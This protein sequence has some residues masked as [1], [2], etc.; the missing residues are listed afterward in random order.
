[1]V[2]SEPFC[3]LIAVVFD[4]WRLLVLLKTMSSSVVDRKME[5]E[6]EAALNLK[7]SGSDGHEE[8][9]VAESA[10]E[11]EVKDD[12]EL[13][14]DENGREKSETDEE[15][16]EMVQV[17]LRL[18]PHEGFDEE[19]NSTGLVFEPMNDDT[20]KVEDEMTVTT[21]APE[22]SQSFKN[23]E[24]GGKYKFSHIFGKSTTQEDLFENTM[25][26][27]LGTFVK[28]S[29]DGLLFAY[30]VTNAGKTYT[31]EGTLKNPGLIPRA[32][33][34]VFSRIA[35]KKEA[36]EGFSARVEISYLQ[37]YNEQVHDLQASGKNASALM[38]KERLKIKLR[39]EGV[40]VEGLKSTEINSVSQGLS[41]ME[42]GREL[43]ETHETECNVSSS[44][45]HSVFVIQLEQSDAG[46]NRKPARLYIVDLA[47]SE[48]S[49]RT[50][51]SRERQREASNINC[52]LMNLMRCLDTLR[53]NQKNKKL[54]KREK[55]VPFRESK[56]TLLFRDCFVGLNCGGV[57][58]IVNA[59]SRAED[60]D[61]T[62]HALKYG[63]LVKNV[64][65]TRQKVSQRTPGRKYGFD[66]R[67]IDPN[68]PTTA[69]KL[70]SKNLGTAG[71]KISML[72]DEYDTDDD[73][74]T[75]FDEDNVIAALMVELAEARMKCVTMES[76]IREEV[77]EEMAERLQEME[78]VFHKRV[79]AAKQISE[80]KSD[81][82]LKNLRK[83][84]QD[85]GKN[86]PFTIEDIEV[87]NQ[88]I[89]ECE[90]EMERMR[91]LHAADIQILQRDNEQLRT[92]L[93]AAHRAA[94]MVSVAGSPGRKIDEA[95]NLRK[96]SLDQFSVEQ[97]AKATMYKEDLVA[98][99]AL[100]EKTIK[101][102][103]SA[104]Q[105]A[106]DAQMGEA[107][108]E[109]QVIALRLEIQQLK[110]HLGSN[111]GTRVEE[112]KNS[113]STNKGVSSSPI[114]PLRPSR[115]LRR[116]K[117]KATDDDT[118]SVASGSGK[119]ISFL[120]SAWGS[121][122]SEGSSSFSKK[123]RKNESAP[124]FDEAWTA[125]PSE[126][127]SASGKGSK[128]F[129]FKRRGS[130]KESA[131]SKE[132]NIENSDASSTSSKQPGLVSR[133]V[134]RMRR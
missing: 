38:G 86:H 112:L 25:L 102:L 26:P 76:Q 16:G 107:D 28:E 69:S 43:R 108:A 100:H 105:L 127:G 2:V 97:L 84:M 37:V 15:D 79:D 72:N 65:V 122:K 20:L 81:S 21:V 18:R 110:S 57:T 45:S 116:G 62:A 24:T 13:G 132:N 66:G 120:A 8:N 39:D 32:L 82:L 30:G 85:G 114:L 126:M 27:L 113:A 101:Q 34:E 88:N 124:A 117:N 3:F 106:K 67:K 111:S 19:G 68:T 129:S 6:E 133:V 9:G 42:K 10:M 125:D 128:A 80:N 46:E 130:L 33:E 95:E 96:K 92:R 63:A 49:K 77:A 14:E 4:R 70:H 90:Q 58:M 1:V 83:R 103:E 31:V 11:V 51:S 22:E 47:G 99:R 75:D 36:D 93:A 73:L 56:L 61:E 119:G 98:E 87:L 118:S 74:Q 71:S 41:I 59:S 115:A 134:G 91:Q 121:G 50:N 78:Q 89:I 17:F 35:A 123:M 29:K 5:E 53:L 55:M 52:S 64:K 54:N 7:D 104:T 48:R 44:R 12:D 131:S 60:Y 94:A 40:E 109:R 23:R